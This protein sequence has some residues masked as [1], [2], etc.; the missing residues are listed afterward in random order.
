MSPS[1]AARWHP[2]WGSVP[3]SSRPNKVR[4]CAKGIRTTY[5]ARSNGQNRIYQNV[6]VGPGLSD[7][8]MGIQIAEN[9]YNWT[10]ANNTIYNASNGIYLR[11]SEDLAGLRIANNIVVRTST[12]YNAWEWPAGLPSPAAL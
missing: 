7:D 8:S 9:S 5:S 10:V 4:N 1:R 6:I 2:A 3:H 11:S 12:S